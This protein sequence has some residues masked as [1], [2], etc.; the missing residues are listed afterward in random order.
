MPRNVFRDIPDVLPDEMF[1]RINSESGT[2]RIERIV[3]RGHVTPPDQWYDQ[4]QTEWVLLL[5]GAAILRFEEGERRVE[6]QPGDYIEIAVGVRHRVE[7]T[8]P[9]V[10][11]VWLAIHY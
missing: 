2:A 10:D 8:A 3:S 4:D 1:Q 11:T 7:W 9:D 5:R 6:L